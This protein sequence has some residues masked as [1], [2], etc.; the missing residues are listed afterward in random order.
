MHSR[1]LRRRWTLVARVAQR[2]SGRG[3]HGMVLC[4]R[5]VIDPRI[6]C[7]LKNNTTLTRGE[8]V[9]RRSGSRVCAVR[10]A[11]LVALLW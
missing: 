6:R 8:F 10:F 11:E 3:R 9:H 7:F 2:S 4:G 5:E 1:A